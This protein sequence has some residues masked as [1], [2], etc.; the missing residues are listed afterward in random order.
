MMS[1]LRS[2]VV[3]VT[4]LV[5]GTALADQAT[6]E[7][8]SQ[9]RDLGQAALRRLEDNQD[10]A[11]ASDLFMKAYETS[12]EIAYLVNV[13][14]T[15]RKAKLPHHAVATYRRCLTDGAS[16]LSPEL[17]AQLENDIVIVTRESAQ[18]NVRTDGEPA[19]ILLDDRVVGS[20]SKAA[21]LLVLIAPDAG[22]IHTLK[23][24]RAS[25]REAALSIEKLSIGAPVEIELVP[26][27]IPRTGTIKIE[28]VPNG[29]MVKDRGPAP[30]TLE[31][32]PGDYTFRG[33]LS[34]YEDAIET[35]HIEAGETRSV[36]LALRRIPPTWWGQHKWKVLIGAGALV[37][38][39]G[40][41]TTRQL[42][43]PSYGQRIDYP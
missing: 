14:V 35:E 39:A 12:G 19:E 11:G 10:Y 13:A 1:A 42:L 5:A 17:R 31:L 23:A 30:I 29:A 7:Q 24:R 6:P 4:L 43:E 16:T 18:V 40:A 8:R 3:A 9:A 34:G 41:I 36:T 33:S 37:V 2:V 32:P 28:S 22:R 20:A 26:T 25:F 27:P 15:Q 38:V 21:P